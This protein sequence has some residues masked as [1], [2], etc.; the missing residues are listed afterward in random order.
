MKVKK[1]NQQFNKEIRR[2]LLDSFL[3]K[4][5]QELKETH[6]INYEL[7]FDF[8]ASN[9][10]IEMKNLFSF[11]IYKFQSY[12]KALQSIEAFETFLFKCFNH[13]IVKVDLSDQELVEIILKS[14]GTSIFLYEDLVEKLY[15]ILIIVLGFCDIEFSLLNYVKNFIH[16]SLVFVNTKILAYS[17]MVLI[18]I[19]DENNSTDLMNFFYSKINFSSV[20][21]DILTR[22][23]SEAVF[24]FFVV[25]CEFSIQIKKE[26]ENFL[27]E[28]KFI[29]NMLCLDFNDSVTIKVCSFVLY[30]IGKDKEIISVLNNHT[31][32]GK[33]TE[34]IK[35]SSNKQLV[36]LS[37]QITT[38]IF[39]KEHN[40]KEELT[41]NFAK[42]CF[43][44]ITNKINK[45]EIEANEN[46][47]TCL[48][49][50][51]T[52]KLFKISIV[53]GY[54]LVYIVTSL[55]EKEFIQKEKV[56]GSFQ[57]I[58]HMLNK[59]KT[60]QKLEI[61]LSEKKVIY[62]TVS[63]IAMSKDDNVVLMALILF[64]ELLEL[65]KFCPK[66]NDEHNIKNYIIRKELHVCLEK[67]QYH[68][69]EDISDL[70]EE[71]IEKHFD[72]E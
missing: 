2:E 49:N 38:N 47:L 44:C 24:E 46:N 12:Q 30:L 23:K 71:L 64:G 33:L 26:P 56:A 32:Q 19:A 22:Y 20:Y 9:K 34:R 11:S 61:I 1:K 31:I 59:L 43:T 35:R 14:T 15:R 42:N 53:E 72:Y 50:I 8:D 51:L 57:I 67:I 54:R 10:Y 39:A 45:K 60:Q 65:S 40:T 36:D 63:Q 16:K 41:L 27:K 17:M 3:N 13:R 48:S 6:S 62:Y 58:I 7:E 52:M 25:F 28:T 4:K 55:F 29:I 70:A 69:N 66:E 21:P 68:K 18:C 37:I 5:R